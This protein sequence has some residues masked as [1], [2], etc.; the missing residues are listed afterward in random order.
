MQCDGS[1]CSFQNLENTNESRFIY[2]H[3]VQNLD[4]KYHLQQSLATLLMSI[5]D[6][7]WAC[8]TSK[9]TSVIL[10]LFWNNVWYATAIKQERSTN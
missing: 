8:R 1:S 7:V 2:N 10:R 9:K 5:L 4:M 3:A 6:G